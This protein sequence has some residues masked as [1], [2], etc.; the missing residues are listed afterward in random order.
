MFKLIIVQNEH[1]VQHVQHEEHALDHQ[2]SDGDE[3]EDQHVQDEQLLTAAL[4]KCFK[5]FSF[6]KKVRVS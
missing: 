1:H 5:G 2:G 3:G 4:K 6:V